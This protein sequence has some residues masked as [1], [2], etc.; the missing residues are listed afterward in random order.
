MSRHKRP[1]GEEK[2]PLAGVAILYKAK[3]SRHLRGEM[4]YIL[5]AFVIRTIRSHNICEVLHHVGILGGKCLPLFN[6]AYGI[7]VE[8]LDV[9]HF[10]LYTC[11]ELIEMSWNS[12]TK[13]TCM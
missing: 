9:T 13:Y 8:A 4:R 6:F 3:D 11:F 10:N 7:I 5:F 1:N 12:H 2:N